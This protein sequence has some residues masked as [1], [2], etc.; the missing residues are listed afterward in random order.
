MGVCNFM[1]VVGRLN[2]FIQSIRG[3][4]SKRN[5][6]KKNK[7]VNIDANL[8]RANDLILE[9]LES[10]QNQLRCANV[11][12][13]VQT[14]FDLIESSIYHIDSLEKKYNYLLKEVRRRQLKGVS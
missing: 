11:A 1:K 6:L 12:F 5:D 10:V 3:V 14:N 7:D 2:Y 8:E 13:N 9:E 4:F